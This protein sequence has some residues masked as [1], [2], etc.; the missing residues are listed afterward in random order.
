MKLKLKKISSE[1]K[2]NNQTNERVRQIIELILSHTKIGDVLS[3]P[4]THGNGH[5][6][7][8]FSDQ[9]FFRAVK[10]S[11]GIGSYNEDKRFTY[12][13]ICQ[14]IDELIRDG[15]MEKVGYYYDYRIPYTM[16][17]VR[18]IK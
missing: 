1:E 14:A 15:I 17:K 18:R 12:S 13:E 7:F 8:V 5:Y 6:N 2:V 3:L 16:I 9:D 11:R 4:Y 10:A